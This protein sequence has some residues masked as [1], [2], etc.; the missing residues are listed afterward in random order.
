MFAGYDIFK[1][2]IIREFWSKQP[3]SKYRPMLFQKLYPYLAQ[4]QGKNMSMLRLFFGYQLQETGSPFYSHLLRWKNT[5]GL[6]KLFNPDFASTITNGDPFETVKALLPNG[7]E[8]YDPLAKSQWLES[9]IFM[10]GYLLSSQGDRMGMANSV[11][12]R[13]PFLDYRVIEF[14]AKLP[15]GYKMHGL[16]EKYILKR[17]MN[18]RLPVNVIK[19]PKQ[20]YR[21][22]VAGSFFHSS[23]KDF[24]HGLLAADEL[25]RTGVFDPT[26]VQKLLSKVISGVQVTEMENMALAGIL[27]TQLLYHQYIIKDSFIPALPGI[28]QCL[29]IQ[30]ENI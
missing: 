20:A 12:G 13:Y 22:P 26:G 1:E 28:G 23:G 17:M 16:N 21:A 2:G 30:E 11:E 3:N 6:Q 19:R 29:V 8:N 7:F 5:A 15:P 14:A 27:S 4:F 10:S 9:I 18:N 24:T 25:A